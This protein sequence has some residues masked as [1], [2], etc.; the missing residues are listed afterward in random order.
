MAALGPVAALVP[1]GL[2]GHRED[3]WCVVLPG[4]KAAC[5]WPRCGLGTPELSQESPSWPS[6]PL[7]PLDP[8]L[9]PAERE[10]VLRVPQHRRPAGGA[11]RCGRQGR[12]RCARDPGGVQAAPLPAAH[13]QVPRACT[14]PQCAGCGCSLGLLSS[15]GL[16]LTIC[17]LGRV[18]HACVS[19]GNMGVRGCPACVAC[20]MGR[21]PSPG[22]YHRL[23][24][25]EQGAPLE[26]Q[27]DAFI[28]VLRVSGGKRGAGSMEGRQVLGLCQGPVS[29]E[30][31]W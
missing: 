25:P 4:G 22:R 11:P 3:L 1:S 5:P 6:D 29:M 19:H 16:S 26:A 17:R 7:P 2:P 18:P 14:G 8:R 15:C 28:S 23:P 10:Q 9:C 27:F 30:M 13:L 31:P 21:S 12:G 24:L 20:L